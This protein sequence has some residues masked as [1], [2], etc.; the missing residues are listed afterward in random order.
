MTADEARNE[1]ISKMGRELGEVYHHLWQEVASVHQKWDEYVELFGTKTTRIAC[2]RKIRVVPGSAN[3]RET[4]A[5]ALVAIDAPR[6]WR[7][8][9]KLRAT[10]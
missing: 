6:E 10:M 8:R 4:R 2:S 9:S 1:Y 5:S 7:D 3:P